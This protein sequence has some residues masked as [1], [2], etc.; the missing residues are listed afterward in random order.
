KKKK[1]VFVYANYIVPMQI[2]T[3]DVVFPRL[4]SFSYCVMLVVCLTSVVCCA[5]SAVADDVQSPWSDV[6]FFF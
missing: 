1:I 4:I 6:Y 5:C 3:P 2:G